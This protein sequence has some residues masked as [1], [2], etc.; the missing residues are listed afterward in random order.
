MLKN[1]LMSLG[2]Y[3]M[4]KET[5][6]D[7]GTEIEDLEELEADPGLGNGGLGRLA[8]CF[9]DSLAS[10]DYAG[11]GNTIRYKNGLFKQI[12]TELMKGNME[13]THFDDTHIEGTVNIPEGMSLLATSIAFDEG[14]Q[15]Y[16]DGQR[17]D[18]IKVEGSLLAVPAT[19]GEHEIRMVYLPRCYTVGGAISLIGLALF[20]LCVAGDEIRKKLA[21]RRWAEENC[22]F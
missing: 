17:A 20:A 18:L 14:W 19:E 4:V 16:V 7:I 8:A 2:K 13:I 15:V 5:L 10:L 1:N 11:N 22:I 3:D 12:F 6:K 9:L 21:L